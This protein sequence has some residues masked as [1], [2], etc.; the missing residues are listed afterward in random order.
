[1]PLP[2][3]CLLVHVAFGQSFPSLGGNLGGNLGITQCAPGDAC[4]GCCDVSC[5]GGE[6]CGGQ[7]VQGASRQCFCKSTSGSGCFAN[8]SGTFAVEQC[9]PIPAE[10]CVASPPAHCT[11]TT[12]PTTTKKPAPSPPPPAP[13]APSGWI[14]VSSVTC[15]PGSACTGCCDV[16]CGGGEVCGGQCTS[17]DGKATRQC[18]CA[19]GCVAN[20]PGT[21][22]MDTCVAVPSECCVA[23]P[24][25]QCTGGGGT[26][27][28]GSGQGGNVPS[29]PPLAGV[30][31]QATGS[32]QCVS[33]GA[34][35]GCC[36]VKCEG[37]KVDGGQC[38]YMMG[39]TN[40]QCTCTTK[41]VPD[42]PGIFNNDQCI[43]LG[44]DLV[45]AGHAAVAAPWAAAFA[46]LSVVE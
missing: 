3:M 36:D 14:Q 40:R 43:A 30:W 24:S 15:L 22:I 4:T 33:G 6:H 42:A 35:T 5:E 46:I 32:V 20:A 12:T 23:N 10:C 19:K 18:A 17:F 38:S 45:N 34:C 13:A 16:K 31:V 28:G 25:A 39:M 27:G 44:R 37:G 1:M 26:P 8:P 2:L 7:C 29:L 11:P 41:C 21:F 9:L